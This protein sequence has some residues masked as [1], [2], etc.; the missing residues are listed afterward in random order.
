MQKR[1]IVNKLEKDIVEFSKDN[2]VSNLIFKMI[3][4]VPENTIVHVPSPGTK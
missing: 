4:K 3:R 2:F 1:L